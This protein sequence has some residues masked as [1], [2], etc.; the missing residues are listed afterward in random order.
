[1]SRRG[2]LGSAVV[3][4]A[5]AAAGARR[6]SGEEPQVK[7]EFYELRQYR[8]R[9]GAQPRRLADYLRDAAIPALNRLGHAPIGVFDLATGDTP[10]TFVLIPHQ[11]LDGVRTLAA[12]LA[13]DVQHRQAGAAFLEAPA[14]DPPYAELKSELLAAFDSMPRIEVPA[15]VAARSPRIFELRTYQSHSE[16]ANAK[17]ME[18]FTPKLGELEIFRR[19]GLNPVFFG[20]ALASWRLPSFTYML[21]FADEAARAKAWSAFGG[22]PAWSK[23]KATPGYSDAD[24]LASITSVILRPAESSQV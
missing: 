13:A 19:V 23:L 22:D 16:A 21:T 18:M 6:A 24:I 7:I 3:A 12:R 5:M 15:A 17:K 1:M 8:L 14:V 10:T 11:S 4:G 9:I 20:R 2:F